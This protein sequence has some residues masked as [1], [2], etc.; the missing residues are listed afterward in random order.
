M[1]L[2]LIVTPIKSILVSRRIK[3]DQVNINLKTPSK[4]TP[5]EVQL[6]INR[7]YDSLPLK[8]VSRLAASVSKEKELI[9]GPGTYDHDAK[10]IPLYKLRPS[11]GFQSKS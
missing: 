4:L 7:K 8:K 11:V 9:V 2:N 3:L 1:S 10:L 5:V 6:G